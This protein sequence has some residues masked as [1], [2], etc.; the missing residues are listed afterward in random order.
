MPQPTAN[1]EIYDQSVIDNRAESIPHLLRDRVAASG[2]RDALLYFDANEELVHLSW[3][4]TQALVDEQAAG[5]IALGVDPEDRVAIASNTRVEWVIANLAIMCAGAATTTIY[6][7]TAADDV[8]FIVSDS[9]TRVIF[10]E[11]STQVAKLVAEREQIPDVRQ[12]IAFNPVEDDV[13][14]WVTTLDDLRAKGRELLAAEPEAVDDRIAAIH[15][16]NLATMLYTSGTTGRP[17]GVRLTHDALVYEGAAAHSTAMLDEDDLQFLWLPLSHVFGNVLLAFSLQM[18]FPTCVDGRMDRIIEHLAIVKP[19]FMGAAPRIF[20][21]AYGR[22]A[23][24]LG[25]ETGVKKA[26]ID[27]GL[28]VGRQVA[29]VKE[30][31]K[32]PNPILSVQHV[33]ADRLVLS[34]VR[35]RF[36]G[37]VKFFVS[38]SA[39]LD[40]DIARWFAAVGLLILEGYGLTE[41]S[42]A[43]CVN[44]PFVGGY[45]FGSIGWPMPG[46]EIK[47]ASDGELLIKGP[48]VMSG[49]HGLDDVTKE[50]FDAEGYFHSGDIGEIDERGFVKITDRKKDLF[51]TSGGKYIA[52]AHIEANFKGHCPFVSQFV[53]AGDGR[54][55][56]TALMTLDADAITGWAAGHGMA[57]T[58]YE[59][60]S[61]SPQVRELMQKYI[62]HLNSNLNRWETIKKFV[63]L[64]HDLSIDHGEL[65]PSLKLKRA[66]V[67]DRY[68]DEIEALYATEA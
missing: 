13:D 59:E 56:A 3:N 8:A 28:G 65:T 57:G 17:K 36:G 12:V 45:K 48:G 47:L 2:P 14:G 29:E 33:I 53:V 42:A 21:K 41:T 26:L 63:I 44:R 39:A 51:K 5:L 60:I 32:S 20:E 1:E 35:E 40:P 49:Y 66:L 25:Q 61:Q 9:G 30:Q 23:M 19:T 38:G 15:R 46:T 18:G 50:A 24:M 64:D 16:D 10:A 27:W 58:S 11:D 6:P 22:I 68:R 54:N 37:R 43:T 4:Q 67:L 52:P 7:T 62:D 31:G 34:K 55:F